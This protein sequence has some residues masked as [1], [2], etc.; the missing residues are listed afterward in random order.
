MSLEVFQKSFA[1]NHKIDYNFNQ[2]VFQLTPWLSWTIVKIKSKLFK[3]NCKN[4]CWEL[5]CL[6]R[7]FFAYVLLFLSLKPHQSVKVTILFHWFGLEN[8]KFTARIQFQAL[9]IN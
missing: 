2:S 8:T 1:A 6:E 9:I 5:L 7:F 4:T 3:K